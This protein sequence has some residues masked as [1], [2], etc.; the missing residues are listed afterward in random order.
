MSS[1]KQP[2]DIIKDDVPQKLKDYLSMWGLEITYR[3]ATHNTGYLVVPDRDSLTTQT[4]FLES[5][6]ISQFLMSGLPERYFDRSGW[7]PLPCPSAGTLVNHLE[8]QID[9]DTKRFKNY[10]QST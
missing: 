1:E 3:Q 8:Q 4:D 2:E 6:A 5:K 10:Q 9:Y 7:R